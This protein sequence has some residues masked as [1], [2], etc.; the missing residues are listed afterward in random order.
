MERETQAEIEALLIF[1]AEDDQGRNVLAGRI[2][3]AAFEMRHLYQDLGL[4]SRAQ[5]NALMKKHYPALAAMK[6]ET[7]RWKKFLFDCVEAVAPACAACGDQAHC[8]SCELELVK[9]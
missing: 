1:Y 5:M 9:N 2:A 3:A 7:V 8:F 6:P 4:P